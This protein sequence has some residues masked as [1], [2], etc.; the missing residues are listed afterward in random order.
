MASLFS[1]LLSS[2]TVRMKV[3][4]YET[5]RDTLRWHSVYLGAEAEAL[6]GTK[7]I[8]HRLIPLLREFCYARSDV[9]ELRKRSGGTGKVRIVLPSEWARLDT[10]TAP[11]FDALYGRHSGLAKKN[12]GPSFIFEEIENIP[13]YARDRAQL[14]HRTSYSWTLQRMQNSRSVADFLLSLRW[15][16]PYEL[17]LAPALQLIRF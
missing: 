11:L 12:T 8:Q 10:C 7:K 1:V 17:V 13:K 15:G 4:H 16:T 5:L 9:L 2:G 3:D 14:T 6:P